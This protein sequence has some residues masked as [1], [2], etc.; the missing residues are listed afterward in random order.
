MKNKKAWVRIVE[1]FIA[2]TLI[3]SV[4][5]TLYT[6]QLSNPDISEEIYSLQKAVLSQVSND[7][8]L[9]KDVLANN[10]DSIMIFLEDK[11]PA[12][13]N[14]D[15]KICSLDEVCSLDFYQKEIYAS[16]T[17]ISSTLQEYSP[18]VIKIFMWRK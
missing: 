7:E 1:A 13:L 4:L 10:K 5:I 3:F 11:I 6:K 18:K 15:I 8:G 14:Y 16:E 2:I 17:V 9:R 12:S